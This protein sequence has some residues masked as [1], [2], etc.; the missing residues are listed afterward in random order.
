MSGVKLS[1]L[2]P[3]NMHTSSHDVSSLCAKEELASRWEVKRLSGNAGQ[4]QTTGLSVNHSALIKSAARK[5]GH[6]DVNGLNKARFPKVETTQADRASKPVSRLTYAQFSD[7]PLVKALMSYDVP[8]T[9]LL[10]VVKREYE[11]GYQEAETISDYLFSEHKRVEMGYFERFMSLGSKADSKKDVFRRLEQMKKM[12]SRLEKKGFGHLQV[13]DALNVIWDWAK[14][15]DRDAHDFVLS[16]VNGKSCRQADSKPR[17]DLGN[18]RQSSG[19]STM[20]AGGFLAT[21]FVGAG[22]TETGNTTDSSPASDNATSST[23]PEVPTHFPCK[24]GTHISR[25]QVCDKRID[26]PEGE[27]ELSGA[28]L[29]HCEGSDRYLCGD[30]TEC[31][32]KHLMCDGDFDCRDGS[33]ESRPPCACLVGDIRCND[34][35]KCLK[36][37]QI[38]DDKKDCDNGSDEWFDAC[39]SAFN[40]TITSGV[41]E[42]R[43][44]AK[45]LIKTCCGH[46][47]ELSILKIAK[48]HDIHAVTCA[49]VSEIKGRSNNCQNLCRRKTPDD[50]VPWCESKSPGNYPGGHCLRQSDLC[51]DDQDCLNNQDEVPDMC[52]LK[53]DWNEVPC[54]DGRCISESA[55]CNGYSGGYS[56]CKNKRDEDPFTC[57]SERTRIDRHRKCQHQKQIPDKECWDKLTGIC[58][59]IGQDALMRGDSS[60]SSTPSINASQSNTSDHANQISAGSG[61]MLAI[62]TVPGVLVGLGISVVVFGGL[63]G[64]IALWRYGKG[65]QALPLPFSASTSTRNPQESIPFAEENVEGCDNHEM[66]DVEL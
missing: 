2:P 27:D 48:H 43:Y 7:G 53:C 33:D 54:G 60:I 25:A 63:C 22:A 13:K 3:A 65:R 17:A 39:A 37:E 46:Q 31:I 6:P 4:S 66:V 57:T 18:H 61:N 49:N 23:F 47:E 42:G 58:C 12:T 26:C 8:I 40:E 14:E 50:I 9:E 55:L 16:L 51:D 5:S 45:H 36:K 41:D 56:G 11:S 30:A 24:N 10:A 15:N 1:S 62:V 21:A 32:P 38:C 52:Y 20:L 29:D 44:E 64:C 19:V 34:D 59:R 28:C 35:S